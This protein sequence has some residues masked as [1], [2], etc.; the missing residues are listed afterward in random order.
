MVH[1]RLGR[2]PSHIGDTQSGEQP[3]GRIVFCLFDGGQKLVC[4]LLLADDALLDEFV[5]M[6]TQ[7]EDIRK[8][9]EIA[10]LDQIMDVHRAEALDIHGGPGN[11]MFHK[12]FQ[13]GGTVE[14][15]ALDV[16]RLLPHR[17]LAADRADH[18][19]LKHLRPGR[20]LFGHLAHTLGDDLPGFFDEQG[21]A[22][23]DIQ[24]RDIVLVVEGASGNCGAAEADRLKD[25]GRGDLPGA[26][27]GELN[28]QEFGLL[29]LRRV[30]VGHLITGVFR[31]VPQSLPGFQFVDLDD[32]PVDV[33]GQTSPHLAD[34]FHRLPDLIHGFADEVVRDHSHAAVP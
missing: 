19:D 10:Q 6:I 23:A 3:G 31:R 13:L 1:Q 32:G 14:V 18:G 29:S 5:P 4:V 26:A 33:V 9:L 7:G 2:R 30:F 12:P 11:E 20:P 21:R 16:R 8:V 27:H 28:V 15:D 34:G 25:G 22:Q 17:R 24:I